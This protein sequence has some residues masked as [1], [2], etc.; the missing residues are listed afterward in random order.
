M[1]TSSNPDRSVR[2]LDRHW[3]WLDALPL[4]ADAVLR[5]L[6]EH[7]SRDA[8]GHYRRA[9]AREACYFYMRDAAGDRPHFEDAARA[10]FAGDDVR[11]RACIAAW[12][13]EV[14]ARIAA[15]LDDGSGAP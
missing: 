1:S 12:P 11:L 3:H 5:R 13:A 9:A 10:L 6:V 8:D 4:G 15:M 2:L 7:A 14:R